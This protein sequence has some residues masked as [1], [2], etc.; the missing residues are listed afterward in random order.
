M[1][2]ATQEASSAT[3]EG[4]LQSIAEL[5]EALSES[6]QRHAQEVAAQ[7][8]R[9]KTLE[10]RINRLQQ[11]PED[12]E[13]NID[14]KP[15][16]AFNEPSV[17]IPKRNKLWVEDPESVVSELERQLILGQSDV[18]WANSIEVRMHE[19]ITST[20]EMKGNELIDTSCGS[21]FCRVEFQHENAMTESKFLAV[22]ASRIDL[23]KD[24][25]KYFL[26]RTAMDD[27]PN[28]NISS[29]FFVSRKGYELPITL[30]QN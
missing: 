6:R 8:L 2:S 21:T 14:S 24:F 18:E 7:A 30:G 12:P 20:P 16:V 3:T 4:D 15:D 11:H 13:L 25:G 5:K 1:G 22:V 26:Y 27:S 9:I 19:L 29:V 28:S 10:E 23:T 17:S